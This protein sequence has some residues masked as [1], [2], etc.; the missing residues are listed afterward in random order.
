MFTDSSQKWNWQ[1]WWETIGF[2]AEH[3]K[4]KTR[5]MSHWWRAVAAALQVIVVG[6]RLMFSNGSTLKTLNGVYVCFVL[7]MH[8]QVSTVASAV[9][10]RCTG[11]Q[12]IRIFV[13]VRNDKATSSLPWYQYAFVRRR[14]RKS[15]WRRTD[16]R[17]VSLLKTANVIAKWSGLVSVDIGK[18]TCTIG[19]DGD[20]EALGC[21]WKVLTRLDTKCWRDIFFCGDSI[22]ARGTCHYATT[23]QRL[24]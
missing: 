2:S 15:R 8:W 21:F 3:A 17:I 19:H 14:V 16:L 11:R 6:V 22:W 23:T 5:R 7:L 10:K 1:D 24:K 9:V 4:R 20:K 12:D 13:E 18:R